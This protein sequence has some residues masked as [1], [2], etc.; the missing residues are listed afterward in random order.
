[1]LA[2]RRFERYAPNDLWQIDGTQVQLADGSSVWVIDILD[3]HARF[4]LGAMA[5]ER[6]SVVAAWRAIETAITEHGA[7]RPHI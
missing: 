6:F 3:D 4:A 7:P 1:M 5:A 2:W